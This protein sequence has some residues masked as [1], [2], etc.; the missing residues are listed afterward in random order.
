MNSVKSPTWL[1]IVIEMFARLRATLA[2]GTEHGRHVMTQAY[3]ERRDFPV[4]TRWLYA[5]TV[6]SL[7]PITAINAPSAC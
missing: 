3:C 1:S 6:I 7:D 5:G 4:P 2:P